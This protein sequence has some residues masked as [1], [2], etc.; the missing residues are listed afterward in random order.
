MRRSV[1][2]VA[3]GM[4]VLFLALFL[5]LNYLQVLRADDLAED[6]RNTRQLIAEYEVRRGS[7]VAADG[8]A[9]MAGVTDTG[10][11]LRYRRVYDQ[12][13]LYG[14]VTGFHSLVYG[15][16]EVEQAYNEHLSGATRPQLARDVVDFLAGRHRG[17]HDVITTIRPAV[18]RA[19]REALGGQEGA[20]VALEPRTGAILALWSNP[21]YDPNRLAAH[22][23][24]EVKNAWNQLLEDSD[25]PLKNRA[26]RETYPPGSTFKVITAAAALEDGIPPDASFAD[27]VRQELPLT[28]ST[29]GNFGGGS[30]TG[31]G[32]ITFR[33]ALVVS[34]NTTF[35]QLGLALEAPKLV[36]QAERFGL[37]IDW[38]FPLGRVVSEIPA[39]LDPP[40]TAQSAIGQRDVRMTPLQ[41]AMTVSAIANDGVLMTPR[42]VSHVEHSTTGA[43]VEEYPPEELDLPERGAQAMSSANAATLTDMMREVVSS[44]TGT[45]A[46]LPGVEVAGKTGTAQTD[47]APTVSFVSFAPADEPEVAVAVVV[48]DGGNAGSGATGGAVAAPVARA[49]MQAALDPAGSEEDGDDG[50]DGNGFDDT[51]EDTDAGAGSGDGADDTGDTSDGF[52]DTG[53]GED[54][55]GTG[56]GE[57]T[58]GTSDGFGDTGDTGDTDDTGAGFG[59]DPDDTNEG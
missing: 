50:Q 32:S 20:V 40:A 54:T 23:R 27:P 8:V 52:G 19:A 34:C 3:A 45:G 58:G 7:I 49:V 51:G 35:A 16:S 37:N 6:D 15:R 55:G 42:I 31:G 38:D 2:H 25:E 5:N 57:D 12:G 53:T 28:N 41:F 13:R 36:A 11:R 26:L 47:G 24:S 10:G 1:W 22:E 17:G 18:Q 48:E 29:I 43:R 30:C 46:Q 39:D 59:D 4:L 21:P 14:H 56:T 33:Q 44:G 9:E